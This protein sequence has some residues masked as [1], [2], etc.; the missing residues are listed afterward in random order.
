MRFRHSALSRFSFKKCFPGSSSV[1]IRKPQPIQW[2]TVP[3]LNLIKSWGQ[4]FTRKM[5]DPLIDWL[6]NKSFL[7]GKNY[8]ML[9]CFCLALISCFKSKSSDQSVQNSVGKWNK[10]GRVVKIAIRKSYRRGQWRQSYVIRGNHVRLDA[11]RGKA[12]L[13]DDY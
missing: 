8:F 11:G 10:G 1:P 4:L 2:R 9:S 12:L 3:R 6:R 5:A 13:I 7:K